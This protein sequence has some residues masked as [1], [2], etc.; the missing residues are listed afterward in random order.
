MKKSLNAVIR[1]IKSGKHLDSYSTLIL[2]L[3]IAVLSG[4]N[5]TH[6]NVTLAVLLA[7]VAV[8]GG[9]ILRISKS[10]ESI[11]PKGRDLIRWL[12]DSDYPDLISKASKVRMLCVANYRFLDTNSDAFH[13][14]MRRGGTL[15][16]ILLDPHNE[17]GRRVAT[18]RSIGASSRPGHLQSHH[19]LTLLKLEEFFISSP[20][21]KMMVKKS[22]YPTAHVLTI[23]EFNSEPTLAFVVPTGFQHATE[24]RPTLCLNEY[25]DARTF[26]YFVSYYDNLWTWQ[27]TVPV[28]L[29]GNLIP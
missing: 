19:K 13:T 23:I 8:V 12:S 28:E 27:G 14:L 10:V 9:N 26:A 17:C 5:I 11:E 22:T 2:L 7:A 29:N 21:G 20:A 6:T 4:L 3:A 18:A 24:N 15:E 16:S 25:D 1:D